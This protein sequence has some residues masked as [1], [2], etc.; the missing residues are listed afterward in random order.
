MRLFWLK[1]AE[2][3]HH[4]KWPVAIFSAL[5]L[6]WMFQ[7]IPILLKGEGDVSCERSCWMFK[8]NCRD[9]KDERRNPLF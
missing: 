2:M 7:A 5:T 3:L 4:V 6:V 9:E 8:Q 1:L